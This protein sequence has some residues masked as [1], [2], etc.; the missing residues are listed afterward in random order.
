MT[1]PVHTVKY[2]QANFRKY[3]ILAITCALLAITASILAAFSGIR[4]STLIKTSADAEASAL[5]ARAAAVSRELAETRQTLQQARDQLNA[6]REQ[7]AVL[8]EKINALERRLAA[9][10]NASTSHTTPATVIPL[11]QKAEPDTSQAAPHFEAGK[12]PNKGI[13]PAVLTK[14]GPSS[15]RPPVQRAAPEASP[16]AQP[17]PA[18][19]S[20]KISEKSKEPVQTLNPTANEP[21]Q[22]ASTT[23]DETASAVT[24]NPSAAAH[25]QPSSSAA[26]AIEATPAPIT[27][28]S[29][30]RVPSSAQQPDGFPSGPPAA[31]PIRPEKAE[32][33]PAPRAN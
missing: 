24:S 5:H 33:S 26:T 16:H 15:L 31:E 28:V 21:D 19:D 18:P 1:R 3:Q 8:K 14:D 11:V 30:E 12:Q 7:V 22:A 4:L 32:E 27:T 10:E 20:K 6:E 9:A 13:A 17:A 29:E 25:R 23:R 2:L